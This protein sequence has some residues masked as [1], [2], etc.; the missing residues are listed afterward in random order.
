MTID[1]SPKVDKFSK[2][3]NATMVN[4]PNGTF[5]KWKIH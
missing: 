5:T 2:R 1:F 4:S 3:K